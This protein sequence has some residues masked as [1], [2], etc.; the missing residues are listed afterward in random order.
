MRTALEDG[1]DIIL[2]YDWWES[3]WMWSTGDMTPRKANDRWR[4]EDR[5][6][7]DLECTE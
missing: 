4:K 1:E 6:V 2:T 3:D 5:N 7:D